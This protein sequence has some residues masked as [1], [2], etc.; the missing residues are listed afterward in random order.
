MRPGVRSRVFSG[1]GVCCGCEP[2]TSRSPLSLRFTTAPPDPSGL[3]TLL[4]KSSTGHFWQVLLQDPDPAALATLRQ[5]PDLSDI[6]DTAV[7]LE[8]V[9]AGLMAKPTT[10]PPENGP[11][12]V[13]KVV[14]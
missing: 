5:R 7:S 2:A 10:A 9:Y 4:E 11:P 8:E 14:E 1:C 3:G 13:R 12:L 6:E